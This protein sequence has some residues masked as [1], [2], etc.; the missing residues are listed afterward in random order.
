MTLTVKFIGALRHASGKGKIT[1]NSKSENLT[2]KELILKLSDETPQLKSSL[3]EQQSDGSFK[4]N[5]LILVNDK[6]ISVLN[7]IETKL[8]EGDEIV[9]VPVVHGG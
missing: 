6:E 3:I 2:V 9:F 4:T 8:S 1:F 7:G 5:A